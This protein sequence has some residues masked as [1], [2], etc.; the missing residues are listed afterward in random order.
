M[1]TNAPA[2]RLL[3]K[4]MEAISEQA[5]ANAEKEENVQKN[6]LTILGICLNYPRTFQSQKNA[7]SA[8]K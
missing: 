4:V 5:T 3:E 7:F 2:D 1:T 8:Q 6:V